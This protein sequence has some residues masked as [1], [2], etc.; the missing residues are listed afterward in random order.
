VKNELEV[1]KCLDHKH[2]NGMMPM[3]ASNKIA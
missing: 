2:V 1:F 3:C